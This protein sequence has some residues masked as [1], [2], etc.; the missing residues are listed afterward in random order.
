MIVW[1]NLHG[2]FVLGLL[3]LALPRRWR[4]V[5]GRPWKMWAVALRA[6]ASLATLVNPFGWH[7]WIATAR[8]LVPRAHGFPRMGAGRVGRGSR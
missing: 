1:A 8:A 2:G 6:R 7:L 5:Y 4:S 3:W